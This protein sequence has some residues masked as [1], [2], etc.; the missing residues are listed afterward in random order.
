MVERPLLAVLIFVASVL[1]ASVGHAGASG[2]LAS[3]ALWGLPVGQ[4]KAAALILN[5]IVASVGT[6]TYARAGLVRL[7]LLVPFTLGSVPAALVGGALPIPAAGLKLAVGVVLAAAALRMALPTRV[8]PEAGPPPAFALAVAIGAVIGLVAG[9]TG[10]GGGIFLSPLL[11]QMRWATP[12][13][14]AAVSAPFILVNSISA[15]VG[16]RPDLAAL[17]A[18]LPLWAV[19]VTFGGVL[20]AQLGA[21]GLPNRTLQRLLAV[22]LAIAAA[23]MLLA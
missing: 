22:V 4:M 23:K 13:A 17:P 20:G 12:R 10:T 11:L 15:L 21:R 16:F 7:P 5:V 14:T 2:Y 1:Y 9:L 3:M 6:V 18:D 19:A 8:E